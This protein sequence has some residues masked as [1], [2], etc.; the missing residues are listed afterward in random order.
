[1]RAVRRQSYPIGDCTRENRSEGLLVGVAIVTRCAGDFIHDV[2][3]ISEEAVDAACEVVAYSGPCVAV[4]L[5]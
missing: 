1:M 4:A 2:I 3:I 5:L